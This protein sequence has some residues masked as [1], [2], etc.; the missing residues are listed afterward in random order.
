MD[1][2]YTIQTN[3]DSSE[4]HSFFKKMDGIPGKIQRRSDWTMTGIL[5]MK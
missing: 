1:F 3:P 4:L 5:S 2:Q